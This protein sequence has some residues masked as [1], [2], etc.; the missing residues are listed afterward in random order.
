M[1]FYG[2]DYANVNQASDNF[3]KSANSRYPIGGYGSAFYLPPLQK[4]SNTG[5]YGSEYG[6]SRGYSAVNQIDGNLTDEG[7][8]AR[9][10]HSTVRIT[11]IYT[12]PPL[13]YIFFF[14]L[15]RMSS[16]IIV[17]KLIVSCALGASERSWLREA[18]AESFRPVGGR[19][20]FTSAAS[21][22]TLTC[23]NYLTISLV[24]ADSYTA[25]SI[26]CT[27]MCFTYIRALVWKKG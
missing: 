16:E 9:I 5:G 3:G 25:G 27:M 7:A 14:L 20:G 26:S 11:H 6:N 15:S 1:L 13:V 10:S 8:D 18:K 12:S 2:R 19:R 21:A 4:P 24:Q 22:A 17:R 23:R